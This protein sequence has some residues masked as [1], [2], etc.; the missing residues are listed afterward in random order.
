MM[1]R[2][3]PY[4]RRSEQKN[5]D[6]YRRSTA[7]DREIS[8]PLGLV[9]QFIPEREVKVYTEEEFAQHDNRYDLQTVVIPAADEVFDD[10][11]VK[12]DT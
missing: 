6:G 9:D 4:I 3:R 12:H 5:D 11:D 1:P 8:A 7:D 2:H 10:V